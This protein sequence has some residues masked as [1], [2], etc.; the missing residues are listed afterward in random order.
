MGGRRLA[1]RPSAHIITTDVSY[2]PYH[3]VF[4]FFCLSKERRLFGR[5]GNGN[6]GLS[7]RT[8]EQEGALATSRELLQVPSGI[9]PRLHQVH[10][11]RLPFMV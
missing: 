3:V 4:F 9:S 11:K 5:L 8:W 2:V 1:A 6:K 10:L 7:G